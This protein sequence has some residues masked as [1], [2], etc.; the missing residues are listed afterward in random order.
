MTTI[1]QLP[2]TAVVH[3]TD[4]LMLDQSGTSAAATVSQLLQ[5]LQPELT[6][7][8]NKLLGRI[9]PVPGQ[10][11]SVDIGH[12]L[13][14]ATT[15]LTVD[16]SVIAPLASPAFSG[17]PTAPT[18]AVGDSSNKIATTAYV[19]A[20][21]YEPVSITG[22]LTGTGSNTIPVTLPAI[23][24]P[25]QFTKVTV[26]AK[27]QVISGL[28]TLSPGD[29]TGLAAV[30]TT[31]SY[32]DLANKP[33]LTLSGDVSG[34]GSSTITATLPAITTPGQFTKVTVNAKGQVT[35]GTA[36]LSPI[37]I[38][39]LATV[40]TTGSY[41]DLA[42]KPTLTLSGD[43]SGTG[44]STITAT[45]PAITTP[46]QFTKVMVNAKGQV[47]SGI[48]T[49]SPTDI[50]GLATV[51]TSGSY[52]D[53][54]NKPS[55]Y[56]LTAATTT[57]LG[58]VK[59]GAN[60]AV[61]PDG[62][63][64]VTASGLDVSQATSVATGSSV[65]RSMASRLAEVHN[66]LDYGA[67][68]TGVADFAPAFQAL[69]SGI[70]ANGGTIY[71][72][73]G[74]YRFNS[75]TYAAGKTL[76]ELDGGVTFVGSGVL[77]TVADNSVLV[78]EQ[79]SKV[80][81]SVSA[82]D[83]NAWTLHTSLVVP[84]TTGTTS[85]EKSA[86]YSA[87][88]S[89]DVSTYTPG[90]AYDTVTT[91]KDIVGLQ[92]SGTILPGTTKGR[93]WGIA[94][95]ATVSTSSDGLATGLEV[96]LVNNGA[97]QPENSRWNSKTGVASINFGP[98]AGTNAFMVVGAGG[99]W[100][101]GYT[102]LKNGVTRNAFVLRDLSTYPS[103]TP[104]FIDAN[105]NAQF[106]SLA[107]TGGTQSTFNSTWTAGNPGTGGFQ[108]NFTGSVPSTGIIG[109]LT[110]VYNNGPYCAQAQKFTYFS[111]AGNADS[112]DNAN[113]LIGIFNPTSVPTANMGAELVRWT[114]GITP[115]DTTHNWTHVVEEY[116]VVNRGLDIGWKAYRNDP[117]NNITG[118]QQITGIVNYSPETSGLG[119]PGEGKNLLFAELFA[120][121]GATNSTGLPARFY[122]ASMYEPNCVVGAVGR[123]IYINGDVTGVAAQIPYAPLEVNLTWLHGLR[124]TTATFQDGA[125]FTMAQGQ[126]IAWTTGSS[127]A[128]LA[129]NGSGAN[130]DIVLT[131]AG[132]GTT[133]VTTLAASGTASFAGGLADASFS[134]QT[135]AN[136]FSITVPNGVSTLQLMP[137]GALASGTITL[138]SSAVNGQWLLIC[139]TATVTS[140]S[141]AAASGQTVFGAPTSLPAYV[142]VS[143]QY[144]ASASRWVCQSGNDTRVT[145]LGSMASQNAASVAIT[146]GTISGAAITVSTPLS[147]DNSITVANTAFVKAQN[148]ITSAG[149]PVQSVVGQTGAVTTAQIASAVAGTGLTGSGGTLVVNY[150]TS[151]TT[152]AAG[153][154]SRITGALSAAT[155]AT[156]YAPLA[157]A[158]L[159]GTPTV[160]TA[161]LNTNT[162]QIASTAFVLGQAGTSTPAMNGTAAVGT[163][164]QF[165]RQ[166]HVHP[167][168]TSRAPTASPTFTG[169]ITNSGTI[170]N[171]GS[172]VSNLG[173]VGLG[174]LL[175]SSYLSPYT[176]ALLFGTG[177]DGSA[178][179]S[180]GTT[181]LSRDTHYTNL[182]INGTGVLN[183]NGHRI[184][185]SGTLDISAAASGAILVTGGTVS[186]AVGS[187]AGSGNGAQFA[188]RD[189]P[190]A[191][192]ALNGVA[193]GTG[194]GATG[195]SSSAYNFAANGGQGGVGGVGGTGVSAGGSAG[196]LA[197]S[198]NYQPNF[199][200][201]TLTFSLYYGTCNTT[202][203]G[204][205]GSSG[206]AGGGD[207]TNAGGGGGAAAPGGGS[208]CLY[209]RFIQRGTNINA[210]VISAKGSNGGNGGNAAGGNAGGGGGGGA[211]GGGFVYIVTEGLLGS[212]ITNAI[213]IS[214]G[215]GGTGG[216]GS[217]TGK[218]GAGGAGGNGG[219]YQII[220][221]GAPSYTCGAFNT[222]GTAGSTTATTSG[223]SGGAGATVRANL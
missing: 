183:P 148:Y 108:W 222:A 22:D 213:D 199:P 33:T 217:G 188:A 24:T 169:T 133:R 93:V 167:T 198:A 191:A 116:N 21:Y 107:I 141:F 168:D 150:G 149:A 27:G 177:A 142:E 214:G 90:T 79:A 66:V 140:C 210:G 23:T 114:V 86:F 92:A 215:T 115:Q 155:A 58:G 216:N 83:A 200:T 18:P 15:A 194:V 175:S 120:Q 184:F 132:T 29:I 97:S 146:G 19:Q 75:A 187:A 223:G 68:P 159:T 173:T 136:G 80:L 153:N 62:T 205:S 5:G 147:S 118:P 16:T 72:P 203:A 181:T 41:T 52:N 30:A 60:L 89:Y 186:N 189:V 39:G 26:N 211:A 96:D 129:S 220:N 81:M 36:T 14:V 123:A 128:T 94:T 35:S 95:G 67:D 44:S 172:L 77:N 212:A 111:S 49:L 157:S 130:Q 45:L 99:T 113:T 28:A 6:L 162:T 176:G 43:V 196:S 209:A 56:A 9:S 91:F 154:D 103:T 20:K 17:A 139:S 119:Q 110:N 138:P 76:I 84:G 37:D 7:A 158:T 47:T 127:T 54:T 42:N 13:A 98:N 11:E 88:S 65:A 2:Q 171:A 192:P 63:L 174:S 4:Q 207:G 219:N 143:F 206:G 117:I 121:S 109:P 201:P 166:D 12:G 145:G 179:I 69:A 204:F 8:Q 48:A 73:S 134:L 10:P 163:A 85:Y 71:F 151:A 202:Y 180:S 137:A 135:P 3:P 82:T 156:T 165:A 126:A 40:A 182:T 178:T 164:T 31:G 32:T 144:Q 87:A 70:S 221:L 195:N 160:P 1:P 64:S 46:G 101:D 34:T 38:T 57:V 50:T 53:L 104:A 125:A 193:G 218:G 74:T 25:G 78:G 61:Q 208:I 185:V 55:G 190:L 152:A 106:Q 170:A 102:V 161:S 100:Y 122:N 124:T 197:T 112:V 59:V 105:G 51:A 131:P